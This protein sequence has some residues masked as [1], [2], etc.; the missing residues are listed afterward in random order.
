MLYCIYVPILERK[1]EEKMYRYSQQMRQNTTNL[2][3]WNRVLALLLILAVGGCAFIGI[4]WSRDSA[5]NARARSALQA[6]VRNCC[7]D[8]KTLAEKMSTSVQSNTALQLAHIRQGVYAMDQLNNVAL[9]LYGEGG[10]LVPAEAL[11]ALY[12]DVDTY[13][14]I[15]Q[16]NTV[17]VLET[18]TLMINHLTALQ[19]LLAE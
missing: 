9:S 1:K 13:F 14:S 19:G 2:R 5:F 10:R 17:S 3:R 7:A 8:A 15:I 6:R 18:R 16:T 4:S 12:E 11:S